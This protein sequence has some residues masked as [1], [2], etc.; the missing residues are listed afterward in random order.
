M[1]VGESDDEWDV[2]EEIKREE[3]QRLVQAGLND[4]KGGDTKT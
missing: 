4:S 3:S 2:G 1:L